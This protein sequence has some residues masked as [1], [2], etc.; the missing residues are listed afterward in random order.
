MLVALTDVTDQRALCFHS[1]VIA[2]VSMG[3]SPPYRMLQLPPRHV[4]DLLFRA[5]G[6]CP[7]CS[8]RGERSCW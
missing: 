5:V 6:S 2:A 7:P 4:M 1:I 8:W 3:L